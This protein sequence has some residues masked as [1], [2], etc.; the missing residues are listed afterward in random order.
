MATAVAEFIL[1]DLE[2]LPT[3][4]LLRYLP[5]ILPVLARLVTVPSPEV[6]RHVQTM[7]LRV[8]PLVAP[9]GPEGPPEIRPNK[10]EV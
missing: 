5:Q 8:C 10:G 9:R 7:L 1:P 3:P 4:T 6:R 2:E